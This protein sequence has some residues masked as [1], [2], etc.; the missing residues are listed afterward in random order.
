MIRKGFDK[1]FGSYVGDWLFMGYC[2][3]LLMVIGMTYNYV[4]S[5]ELARDASASPVVVQIES[6]R[7]I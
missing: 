1:K 4:R 7:Q 6:S 5:E 2:V 3:F